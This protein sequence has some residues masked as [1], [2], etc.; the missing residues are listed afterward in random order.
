M[1]TRRGPS[2]SI[3]TDVV[4]ASRRRCC[5]CVFLKDRDEDRPG[6]IAHLNRDPTDSRFDNLVFLCFEHH[7]EYD[8][9]PSQSKGLL[10]AEVRKYRDQ[11]YARYP[12]L[13]TVAKHAAHAENADLSA[14]PK[15]SQYEEVRKRFPKELYFVS[16]PWRFGL[17]LIANEPELFAYKSRNRIDGVC[18]IERID[19]PDGRIV[20]A[21]IQTAG[22]PGNSITNNVEYL[23]FQVCER[24]E[25]PAERLVWLEHYDYDDPGEWRRVTF[26]QCPPNGPSKGPTWETMTSHMW[27]GLRLQPKKKLKISLGHFESKIKKLFHW[28]KEAIL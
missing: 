3:E 18:L 16:S 28:P 10:T 24:F 1:S 25:I 13:Q 23:C 6:Q 22:N 2:K 27:R 11:L 5:L 26:A 7:E 4:I 14:L 9:K 21:C 8:R 20:I 17:W 15:T 12:N 19:I